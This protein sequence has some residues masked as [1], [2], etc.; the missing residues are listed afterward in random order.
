MKNAFRCSGS[1][2][3]FILY[4]FH[5]QKHF[6]VAPLRPIPHQ[7]DIFGPQEALIDMYPNQPYNMYVY[8]ISYAVVRTL[9]NHN[10]FGIL[11]LFLWI[12]LLLS[13]ELG[14]LF[15]YKTLLLHKANRFFIAIP[16]DHYTKCK[17]CNLQPDPWL[18]VLQKFLCKKS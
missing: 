9:I 6:I 1:C 2:F 18:V 13:W 10:S 16:E 8:S 15:R 5:N 3:T 4:S 7:K 17:L 11:H 12:V 14:L